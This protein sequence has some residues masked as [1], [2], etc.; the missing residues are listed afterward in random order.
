MAKD[1]VIELKNPE[2][3]VEDPLTDILR[4]GA[5][6]I[7][8]AALEAEVAVFLQQYN[9]EADDNGRRRIVRNGYL[10]ERKVRTGSRASATYPGSSTGFTK[11]TDPIYIK[12]FTAVSETDPEY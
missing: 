10:P 4:Q 6:Q 11:G 5:R 3:F 12:Y 2:P 1:N 8:A 7:L 9:E